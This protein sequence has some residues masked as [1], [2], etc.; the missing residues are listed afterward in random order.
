MWFSDEAIRASRVKRLKA[1]TLR[2]SSSLRTLMAALAAEGACPLT[3][4]FSRL[5]LLVFELHVWNVARVGRKRDRRGG[6]KP[7][8]TWT[9]GR[10]DSRE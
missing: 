3:L 9:V 5:P 1:S 4:D 8:S 10:P 2:D 6:C 7:G